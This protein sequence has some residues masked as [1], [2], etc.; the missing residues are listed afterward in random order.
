MDSAV[1]GRGVAHAE[2]GRMGWTARRSAS[3]PKPKV[4]RWKTADGCPVSWWPGSRPRLD[5]RVRAVGGP[6]RL[7]H[8]PMSVCPLSG[9]D[10]L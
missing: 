2:G 8:M 10:Q 9:H 1:G 7:T 3:G 4:S 6:C 5:S